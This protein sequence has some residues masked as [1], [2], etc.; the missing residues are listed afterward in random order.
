MRVKIIE[1]VAGHADER[2]NLEDHVFR[3]GE[4]VELDDG[5]AQSW[6]DSGR[7]AI[8]D[9]EPPAPPPD[10][11]DGGNGGDE[12]LTR[13]KAVGKKTIEPAPHHSQKGK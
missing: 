2:Y 9:P 12:Q 4:I 7:A 3:P 8:P 1:P 6:I 5:L 13:H 11:G 10:G